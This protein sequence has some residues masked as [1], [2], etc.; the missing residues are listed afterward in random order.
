MGK[1]LTIR[2]H[3]NILLYKYTGSTRRFFCEYKSQCHSLSY[4]MTISNISSKAIEPT[5]TNFLVDPSGAEGTK[6]VQMVMVT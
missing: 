6:Y 1:C 2:F 3:G 5:V 4:S